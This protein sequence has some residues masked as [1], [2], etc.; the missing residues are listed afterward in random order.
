MALQG[1]IDSFPV[2][3]VLQLLGA[4]AKTGRLDI[5]G[6]R[7]HGSLWVDQGAIV[8]G[9]MEGVPTTS[10][11]DVVF[12]FFLFSDGSFEFVSGDSP[13]EQPFSAAA[14]EAVES[15]TTML[16]EWEQILEVV[17]GT[18]HVVTLA[19]E[20]GGSEVT[21]DAQDWEVLVASGS[22]PTVGEVLESLG[23]GEFE[24]CRRVAELSGRGLLVVG[25]PRP[26]ETALLAAPAPAG[27]Q[28]HDEPSDALRPDDVV[29][30]DQALA[31]GDEGGIADIEGRQPAAEAFGLGAD[32]G[33]EQF[34]DDDGA[35]EAPAFPDH[36]PIDDLVESDSTVSFDSAA[37]AFGEPVEPAA[38]PWEP[39]SPEAPAT[40]FA[41]GGDDPQP[42]SAEAFGDPAAGDAFADPHAAFS[43]EPAQATGDPSAEG[44][45]EG[46]LAQIGRLSP[47][48][49]EAIAAA[50]GDG[51]DA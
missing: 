23:T 44:T 34:T 9:D 10:A 2:A 16:A 21:L 33:E 7:G 17:P 8:A 48:A 19:P 46:V 6:D 20:L 51:E 32:F 31:G 14:P 5:D 39:L 4:S 35:A 11:A 12:E 41:S 45:S 28:G 47:K 29:T 30:S 26:I 3:D 27:L 24:G 37:G 22:G 1:T 43:S 15:A 25:E 50:L 42:P 18:D 13:L 49:A 40:G 36:F 38:Q